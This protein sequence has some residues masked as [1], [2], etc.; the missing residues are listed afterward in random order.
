MRAVGNPIQ[1]AQVLRDG[2]QQFQ[3][4]P[5][6]LFKRL[7]LPDAALRSDLAA[8]KQLQK[9]FKPHF[10]LF[11]RNRQPLPQVGTAPVSDGIGNFCPLIGTHV[12]GKDHTV[13]R[14]GAQRGIN[15]SVADA[16]EQTQTFV[17]PLFD[18][19]AGHG[20]VAE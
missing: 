13:R 10:I 11:R 19:I 18:V 3:F 12:A 7:N 1:G 16:P 17:D 9:R 6:F 5:R 20:L 14:K 4:R 8:E 2:P 15:A